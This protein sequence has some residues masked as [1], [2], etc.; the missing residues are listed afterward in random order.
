M[1][2]IN[3]V[4]ITVTKLV[5]PTGRGVLILGHVDNGILH[6]RDILQVHNHQPGVT[7][8]IGRLYKSGK[9][10]QEAEAGNDIKLLLERI[11]ETEINPGDRLMPGNKKDLL[12]IQ[13]WE[14]LQER[15]EPILYLRQILGQ[16]VWLVFL[17]IFLIVPV[18]FV[19]P[20]FHAA[21]RSS[22]IKLGLL[23]VFWCGPI[24]YLTYRQVIGLIEGLKGRNIFF[25]GNAQAM[26]QILNRRVAEHDS[27][28][29]TTY[30]YHLQ[31]KFTPTIG[32]VDAGSLQCGASIGK[33]LYENLRASQSVNITYATEDPRIFVIEGE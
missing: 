3:D 25:Q 6:V 32:A 5:K 8:R 13:K 30:T 19:I 1:D 22:L 27:S 11:Q 15:I 12:Q 23:M 18:F 7:A 28:Y 29:S 2:K 31:L 24:S 9:K 14:K 17:G 33:K 16:I 10:I 26:A 21:D 4:Q 20:M